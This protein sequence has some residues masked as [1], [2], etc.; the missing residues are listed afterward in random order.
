MD[1]P[2]DLDD[3]TALILD[4]IPQLGMKLVAGND[5]EI[6]FTPDDFKRYWKQAREKTHS[7]MCLVHF[8][9][10]KAATTSD[11][12]SKFMAK[13]I[14]VIARSGCPPKRWGSGL[15][16]MLENISGVA[17]INKLRAILL[18]EADFNSENKFVFGHLALNKL[19]EEEYIS[20]EQYSQRETTTEDAKMDMRLPY[21]IS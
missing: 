11:S 1:V 10:H 9:H 2:K 3:V 19:L 7:S 12:V 14:I 20:E 16:L 18:M 21:D 4:K 13:K 6:T 5:E 17:L 8:G 15:Q